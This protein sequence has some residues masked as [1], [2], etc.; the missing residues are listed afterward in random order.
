MDIA[1]FFSKYTYDMLREQETREGMVPMVVPANKMHGGGSSAWGDA[2][3][4]VP[5]NVY[6]HFGDKA[7]LEQQIESMQGWVDW[8]RSC[9]E[10][11]GGHR[12]WTTGFHF[13]DWLA[14]DGDDPKTPLG[15][16]PEDFISSA[17][18]Y[19]SARLVAKAAAVLGKEDMAQEYSKLAEEV[20]SAIQAEYFTPWGRIAINTQTA[21]VVALFMDLVPVEHR[22]RLEN[23]LRDKLKKDKYHLKTGFVGTPYLCRVLSDNNNHDMAFRLFL[24]EDYPSWLYAIK[25]DATTIWERWNSL[26]PD[27]TISDLTMNSFNHYSYGSIMEWVYRNVAG[28]KPVEEVPGFRR[29]RLAPQPDSRLQWIKVGLE[30]AAGRYESEWAIQEDGRLTF[31]FKVPFNASALLKLP[32]GKLEEVM[33]NGILLAKNGLTARQDGADVSVELPAGTWDFE[34]MPTRS[35]LRQLTTYTPLEELLK[36][37][38]AL[39]IIKQ[40]FPQVA[41]AT[42]EVMGR[43]L[44]ASPR[45]LLNRP[46]VRV[47]VE[48]LDQ[49]DVELKKI[50][51]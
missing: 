8:I 25:L 21:M 15:G 48:M 17:Y 42:P 24:N 26:L 47:T 43:M 29:A 13:G 23:T 50:K 45:D 37:P 3:T 6:L 19:Y 41:N 39:E 44:Y 40:A 31:H 22:K 7:I 4:I 12:L 14:L 10:K 35:Y 46:F 9:D 1:A 49:L 2:A 28:L 11:S 38:Q 18:Y 5:W 30:S 32:D 34:Y 20:R 27:G 51:L 33:V 36:N 16:T